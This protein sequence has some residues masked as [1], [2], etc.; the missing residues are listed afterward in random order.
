[1][2]R[3]SRIK[4]LLVFVLLLVSA[5]I[6][7][8]SG[9]VIK[10][11]DGDTIV[12]LDSVNVQHTV[13]LADIDCPEYKQPYSQVAKKFVSDEVYM[14][15]VEVISKGSDRYGRTIGFVMYDNG[16]NLSGELLKAGLAWHYIKYSTSPKFRFLEKMA[17]KEGRGL[18]GDKNPIAPWDWRKNKKTLNV[19]HN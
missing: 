13:R 10:V 9:E 1:M 17:I 2:K 15:H 4:N 16:K 3:K 7:C 19:K 8:Q 11:K 14:Q 6:F 18:W 5:S 12:I